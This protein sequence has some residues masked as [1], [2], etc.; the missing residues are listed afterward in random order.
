MSLPP[1][2]PGPPNAVVA[3]QPGMAV[4]AVCAVTQPSGAFL[5]TTQGAIGGN[6]SV[7]VQPGMRV[8]AVCLV[9]SSSQFISP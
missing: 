3:I 8:R 7:N 5:T 2:V 4:Q 1:T 6:T 9:N